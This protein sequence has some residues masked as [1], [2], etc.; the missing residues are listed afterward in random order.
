MRLS[1]EGRSP[2]RTQTLCI[3]PV[4]LDKRAANTPHTSGDQ[5]TKPCIKTS[6]A[7][8]FPFSLG[9][10][11]S[12]MTASYPI[13]RLFVLFRFPAAVVR[14]LRFEI[15]RTRCF[16]WQRRGRHGQRGEEEYAQRLTGEG[17]L[18]SER[19]DNTNKSPNQKL[20]RGWEE[21]WNSRK[22]GKQDCRHCQNVYFL[23]YHV[24]TFWPGVEYPP[25]MF[26]LSLFHV[27]HPLQFCLC[28]FTLRFFST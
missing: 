9:L 7:R 8:L 11:T 21:S 17:K 4:R 23:V 22:G 13:F 6:P 5:Q 25:V 16:P 1:S 18:V 19:V 12:A 14:P 27:R 20:A 10:R 15:D 24:H 26:F 3:P 2:L 28:P